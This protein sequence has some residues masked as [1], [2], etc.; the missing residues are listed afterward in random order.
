M[1][2]LSYII[3][4][5]CIC[6]LTAN[7][8]VSHSLYT[9]ES[10]PQTTVLNPAR[11]PRTNFYVGIPAVNFYI[12]ESS[13]I[14]PREF[15]QKHEGQWITPIDA[16]FDYKKLNRFY[17]KKMAIN[18]AS[19]INIV[20]F[21]WRLT[22]ESYLTFS[23]NERITTDFA[24]PSDLVLL[25]DKGLPNN[26]LLKLSRL[27]INAK[28]YHEFNASFSYAYDDQWTF[29]ARAKYLVGIGAVKTKNKKL[30]LNTNRDIWTL[31]T[32]VQVM[33]SMPSL[34]ASKAIDDEGYVVFDSLDFE[35]MSGKDVKK[36]LMPKL[37]NPGLGLDL[38]ANFIL[39]DNFRF[40]AS[41]TDLGFIIWNKDINTFKTKTSYQ[42]DGIDV[43]M[44]RI[45]DNEDE[46]YKDYLREELDTLEAHLHTELTHRHFVTGLN[47]NIYICGEYTPNHY[48]TLSFL[49]HT[50]FFRKR[51][52]QDFNISAA[53]N[54]YKPFSTVAGL[55]LNTLGKASANFGFSVRAGVLQ[56]YAV[57][58][59]LP[60]RF[61]KY[62]IQDEKMKLPANMTGLNVSV[63]LNVLLGPHG[64]RDKPMI[65][66]YTD[67]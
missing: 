21:G 33:T 51:V 6:S 30:D 10:V 17:R 63:G 4:L 61:N 38:G 42:F 8:Q 16:N 37:Q 50:K 35:S 43:D 28:A 9:L 58:D 45:N 59:Y 62:N 5:V 29:G 39:D 48:L 11:Q 65:N 25:A 22:D 31:N 7:A 60:F 66:A 14:R 26:T 19:T 18:V 32:D 13:N 44:K 3:A 34:D 27:G 46:D 24:L 55:T 40:C 64:Y 54:P 1:K 2:R 67:F 49:S 20:D 57:A 47:P 15:F 23:V 36:A 41:V 53:F 56:L 52:N 12:H